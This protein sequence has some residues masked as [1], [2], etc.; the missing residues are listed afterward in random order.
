M[1]FVDLAPLRD[2]ELVMLTIA[3]ALNVKEVAGKSWLQ[4]LQT[5]LRERQ[6]LMVLDNFEQVI[7]AALQVAELLA[8]CPQ[9]TILV[10]SRE[11]LHLRGEQ[12]YAV[13]PLALPGPT[14]PDMAVLAQNMVVPFWPFF[15]LKP[16]PIQQARKTF[17]MSR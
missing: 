5:F 4:P 11:A 8:G 13:P 9:L 1:V 17:E 16:I 3:R 10:T 2:P 12:E 14:L 7:E 6:V 15:A